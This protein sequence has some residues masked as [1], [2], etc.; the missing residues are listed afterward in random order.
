MQKTHL[1]FELGSTITA[2]ISVT[3]PVDFFFLQ[4]YE[5]RQRNETYSVY[6][7]ITEGKSN[8]NEKKI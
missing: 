2:L 4:L 5:L 3:L 6:S 8:F 1:E 7:L